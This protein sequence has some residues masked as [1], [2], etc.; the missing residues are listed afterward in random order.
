VGTY[1]VNGDHFLEFKFSD[2]PGPYTKRW[3]PVHRKLWIEANGPVP[4]GHVVRFKDGLK[5]TVLEE[6][7]LDRIECITLAE[8]LK[9]NSL[10]RYPKEIQDAMRARG[11]L[12][13]AINRKER[14]SP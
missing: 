1:R 9:R 12:K 10:Y 6:I 5:T 11:L 3:V 7:T 4:S 13:R 2:E 14:T 8:N